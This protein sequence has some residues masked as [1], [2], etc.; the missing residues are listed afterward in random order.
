MVFGGVDFGC[1]YGLHKL[2]YHTCK[3]RLPKNNL[4]RD[5]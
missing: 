5:K 2:E 1:I 3:A 4:K